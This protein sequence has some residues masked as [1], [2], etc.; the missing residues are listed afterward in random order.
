MDNGRT[1]LVLACL[2]LTG[3]DSGQSHAAMANGGPAADGTAA[4]PACEVAEANVPL[5]AEVRETSGLARSARGDGLFWTHNDAGNEPEL[6]GIDRAG[7]LEERVR[8]AGADL[9]DWEDIEMAPCGDRSCLYVGDIG[10]NDGE[11][12]RV[13]I[14]RVPEPAAGVTESEPAEALHARFPDGPRDA[15]GLFIDGTGD[16]FLVTKGRRETVAL[17][18]Y[19]APQRPAETATLEHVRDLFPTPRDRDD[20]VTAAT[21]TPDGRRVGIRTYRNLYVYPTRQLVDGEDVQPAVFDLSSLGEVQGEALVLTNDGTVWL[22][23]EA[24]GDEEQPRLSRL[25]CQLASA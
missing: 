3:C 10:D 9:V 11:R 22:S 25:R 2:F 7:R 5:P 1:L 15:E 17:Y 16:L 13:T 8:I 12:D 6:F 14:Y 24:D 4:D 20:R 18:R 19:P 21:A 23:S